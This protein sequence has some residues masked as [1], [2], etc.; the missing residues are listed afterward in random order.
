MALLNFILSL[1]GLALW[2]N[3]LSGRTDPLV[4]TPSVSLAGTLKR[5]RAPSRRRWQHLA[6]LAALLLVRPWLWLQFSSLV[7]WTPRIR[8]GVIVLSFRGGLWSHLLVFSLLSFGAVLAGFY[9]W[10]LLFSVLNGRS[11]D[12]NPLQ[13]LARFHLGRCER[14][15]RGL[16]CLLPFLLGGCAWLALHPLLARMAVVP[17]GK[18][19]AQLL[20]QAAVMGAGTYL[21]LKYVILLVLLLY[22]VHS[23]VHLGDHPVWEFVDVSARNLL[24]PL[25]WLPLRAGRIDF[26]PVMALALVV[27]LSIGVEHPPERVRLWLSQWLPF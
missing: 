23:Y 26:A 27:M 11:L 21:A 15:P 13:R 7:T 17:A 9:L 4:R 2:A 22:L 6:G 16:Q 8:L 12:A 20:T 19:A 1:A 25:R 14:L 5:T 10:L 24:R 18:S 3:W